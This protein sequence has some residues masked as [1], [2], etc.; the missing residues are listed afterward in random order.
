M[1]GVG[2]LGVG[3]WGLGVLVGGGG[4]ELG[5]REE[6][7]GGVYVMIFLHATGPVMAR[8]SFDA[9][10]LV[11]G[12]FHAVGT[13]LSLLEQRFCVF[14]E[15]HKRFCVISM[16]TCSSAQALL[17][18]MYCVISMLTYA[19]AK[20]VAKYVKVHGKVPFVPCKAQASGGPT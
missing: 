19:C 10:G 17:C 1:D 6:R 9:T 16:L 7:G 11:G 4:W 13:L 5:A 12:P 3:S 18:D 14:F 15:V 8:L 2:G 20:Y